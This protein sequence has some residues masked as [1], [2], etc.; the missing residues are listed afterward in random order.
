MRSLWKY[1][2]IFTT[3]SLLGY[4][5][6]PMGFESIGMGGT[7]VSNTK[8]SMAGYYNPAL[9]AKHRYSTEVSMQFGVGVKEDNLAQH[10]DKLSQIDFTKTVDRVTSKERAVYGLMFGIYNVDDKQNVKTALDVLQSV[11]VQNSLSILPTSALSIQVNKFHIGV[12]NT[13]TASAQIVVDPNKLTLYSKY[14]ESSYMVYDPYASGNPYSFA[15]ITDDEYKEQSL[16]YALNNGYTYLSLKGISLL[17]VPISYAHSYELSFGSISVGTSLKYMGAATY[18]QKVDVDT[19]SDKIA[20]KFDEQTTTSSN[21]G[22]DLGLLYQPREE[23]NI[24]IT[25]KN[26]NSPEF[27]TLDSD[28]PFVVDPMVRA[29]LSLTF[30]D[31]VDFAIDYDITKNDTA[32]EYIKSQYFGGGLNIRP[33]SWFSLRA[34]FMKNIAFED[35]GLIYTTGMGIGFEKF[36]FDLAAQISDNTS[37]VDENEISNYMKI[38]L[39]LV[40]RW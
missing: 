22:I 17:E 27:D 8:G 34:G 11:Y 13:S 33:T 37:S 20:D 31:K 4:E 36:Q 24:G 21:F 15:S 38:N 10:V 40:S 39:A 23:V 28:N 19:K 25:A 30:W 5:F 29:G 14:N 1:L 6:H 26:L 12:Y 9:L 35:E 18:K 32:V 2:M 7:G 3:S 16:E